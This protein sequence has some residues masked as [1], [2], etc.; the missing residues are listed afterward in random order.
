M[1]VGRS[2]TTYARAPQPGSA[3]ALSIPHISWSEPTIQGSANSS[4]HTGTRS[5]YG[6]QATRM[7]AK[8]S[9]ELG[10]WALGTQQAHYGN[11]VCRLATF[12]HSA[13]QRDPKFSI[14]SLN[15][16]VLRRLCFWH[17]SLLVVKVAPAVVASLHTVH[18]CFTIFL[19]L[20]LS[21]LGL[22]HH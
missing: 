21:L 16:F 2:T 1:S 14:E 3:R 10:D 19:S 20:G 4:F 18:Q 9:D 17:L 13:K 8:P 15:L 6:G 7:P 5:S 12:I 11:S 22:D